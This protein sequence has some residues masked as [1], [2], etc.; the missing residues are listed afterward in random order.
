MEWGNQEIFVIVKFLWW[1]LWI[2]DLETCKVRYRKSVRSIIRLGYLGEFE[3]HH[4]CLLNLKFFSK[5]IPCYSLLHLQ[6]CEL[7][8][9]DTSFCE[10]EHD[11]ST[12]M[13]YIDTIGHIAEEKKSLNP[14]Y[15]R[16]IRI[17]ELSEVSLYL[18]E[19]IR[20]RDPRTCLDNTILYNTSSPPLLLKESKTNRRESWIKSE[21]YHEGIIWKKRF[22]KKFIQKKI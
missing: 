7:Y 2:M 20:K 16:I 1:K 13:C 15:L 18:E 4:Q 14:T 11:H 17:E 5:T 8:E 3:H 10:R 21:D 19:S 12:S 9:W 22:Y 6:W